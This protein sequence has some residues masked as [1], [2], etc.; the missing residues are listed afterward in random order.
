[1]S[2]QITLFVYVVPILLMNSGTLKGCPSVCSCEDSDGE[3]NVDCSH[4]GL[5]EIPSNIPSDT[6]RLVLEY[7]DL[8]TIS[9]HAFIELYGM[10]YINLG[11]NGITEISPS[12]FAGFPDTIQSLS[13]LRYLYLTGNELNHLPSFHNLTALEFAL[14]AENPWSCDCHM[15]AFKR[16]IHNNTQ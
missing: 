6:T 1:M 5:S 9:E 3:L 7:N 12:A 8:T 14:L 4:G 10:V 16:W 13:N 11:W 2:W 15:E